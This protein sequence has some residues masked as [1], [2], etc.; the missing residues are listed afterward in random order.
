MLRPSPTPVWGLECFIL[1]VRLADAEPNE[2][3]IDCVSFAVAKNCAG[4]AIRLC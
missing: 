4:S 2:C 3:N 1:L